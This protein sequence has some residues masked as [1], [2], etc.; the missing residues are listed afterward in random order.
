[1]ETLTDF[2][3]Q[4]TSLTLDES[5]IN[6]NL[7]SDNNTNDDDVVEVFGEPVK[8][9]KIEKMEGDD[10]INS[11]DDDD[12]DVIAL[13]TEEP[14]VTEILDD[15]DEKAAAIAA[16]AA[17][18][19]VTEEEETATKEPT[20]EETESVN[21]ESATSDLP[22][23]DPDVMIK[24]PIIETHDVD[25]YVPKSLSTSITN[26]SIYQAGIIKIKEE[27]KDDG[28]EDDG[29]EDVGT[30]EASFVAKEPGMFLCLKMRSR[31]NPEETNGFSFQ[32]N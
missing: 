17:A 4:Q 16:A 13:P 7:T 28:Y 21:G 30:F 20:E 14:V 11:I 6:A 29:F 2:L 32:R 3:F 18:A 23:T 25:E 12:D 26:D 9:E 24:E 8:K 31:I 19:V 15:E 22:D 1:M 5:A 27:P 10:T